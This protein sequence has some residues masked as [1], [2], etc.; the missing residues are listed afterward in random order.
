MSNV[1]YPPLAAAQDIMFA[2]MMNPKLTTADDLVK[3]HK[4]REPIAQTIRTEIIDNWKQRKIIKERSIGS[5]G[6]SILGDQ[7]TI[8]GDIFENTFTV[9]SLPGLTK[10]LEMY[11]K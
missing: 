4:E 10:F 7:I 1:H 9:K 2:A 3:I 5:K 11:I 8:H 6:Y